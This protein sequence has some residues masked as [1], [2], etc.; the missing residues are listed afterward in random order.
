MFLKTLTTLCFVAFILIPGSLAAQEDADREYQEVFRKL[1]TAESTTERLE[2]FKDFALKYPDHSGTKS[3]L[4]NAVNF[5]VHFLE[6]PEP[7][8]AVDFVLEVLKKTSDDEN[9]VCART[10]LIELFGRLNKPEEVRRAVEELGDLSGLSYRYLSSIV[11]AAIKVELWEPALKCAEAALPKTTPEGVKA[12]LEKLVGGGGQFSAA[13]LEKYSKLWTGTI[14]AAKGWVLVNLDR[15]G[16]GLAVFDEAAGKTAYNYV[17]VPETKLN[18][19]WAQT[20]I[21]DGNYDAALK[22]ITIDG[23]F[24]GMPEREELMKEA[25][26]GNCGSEEGFEEYVWSLRFELG[27]IVPDFSLAD[28]RGNQGRFSELKGKVTVLNL[29]S[30]T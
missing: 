2:I 27:P 11:Y 4:R 13:S 5:Y 12:E 10:L 3:M 6:E 28:Y 25:Y 17:G 20:L 24:S 30:P 8:A 22:R 26:I 18:Y 21:R 1:K 15:D 7:A 29:W 9:A 14:L 16:E 19:F 23:I